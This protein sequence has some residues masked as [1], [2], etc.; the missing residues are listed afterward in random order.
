MFACAITTKHISQD[1]L[2]LPCSFTAM[3]YFW[4]LVLC[5]IVCKRY[6]LTALNRYNYS[7][8]FHYKDIYEIYIIYMDIY[9]EY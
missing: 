7:K 1:L 4:S 3:L 6:V 2:F 5:N 8:S 9:E